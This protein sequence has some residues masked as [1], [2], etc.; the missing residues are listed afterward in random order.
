MEVYVEVT[1]PGFM[2]FINEKWKMGIDMLLGTLAGRKLD[3]N[4]A[5]Q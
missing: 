2:S 4:L 5:M 1:M 3:T